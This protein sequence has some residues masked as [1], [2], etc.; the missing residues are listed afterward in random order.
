MKFTVSLLLSCAWL[1]AA[2]AAALWHQKYSYHTPPG[3]RQSNATGNFPALVAVSHVKFFGWLL[4]RAAD[5]TAG[6][7]LLRCLVGSAA[8]EIVPELR[9][10]SLTRKRSAV[11]V[12]L[13]L[14]S[15][16]LVLAKLGGRVNGVHR[17]KFASLVAEAETA[18]IGEQHVPPA[19]CMLPFECKMISNFNTAPE[20]AQAN[21]LCL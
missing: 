15:C 20:S 17:S 1:R 6:V 5:A 21:P 10:V 8:F 2:N 14:Y 18:E 19:A 4:E 13:F 9:A 11:L 7:R 3:A 16:F 12:F